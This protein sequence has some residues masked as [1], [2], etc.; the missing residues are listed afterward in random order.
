MDI[1]RVFSEVEAEFHRRISEVRE[2][3]RSRNSDLKA[4]FFQRVETENSFAVLEGLEEKQKPGGDEVRRVEGS[5]SASKT[6]SAG[7]VL[8][9]GDSQVRHLDT[10]CCDKDRKRRTRLCLPS[11]GIERVNA[12]L[13][14]C[15]AD[16]TKPIVFLSAGEMTFAR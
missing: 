2:E 14:T 15:L 1:D 3:F 6:L 9:I 10:A 8:V 7:K 12:Q 13:D 4:E 5:L 16:G 11:A